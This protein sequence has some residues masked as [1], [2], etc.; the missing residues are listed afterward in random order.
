VQDTDGGCGRQVVPCACME[1]D[2]CMSHEEEDTCMSHKE[3]DACV[4]CRRSKSVVK[5]KCRRIQTHADTH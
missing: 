4:Y 2:T 1:E 5:K 3:E